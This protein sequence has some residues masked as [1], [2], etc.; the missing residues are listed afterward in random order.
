MNSQ[1]L[2]LG[3]LTGRRRVLRPGTDSAGS[4][5]SSYPFSAMGD[6]AVI[7]DAV[8]GVEI[9][10]V[11]DREY[12]LAIPYSREVD[13]QILSFDIEPNAGEPFGLRDR[14]TG[15]VWTIDGRGVDG[16][17]ADKK[18]RQVPAHNSM[19]FAWVT[20]WQNTDVWQ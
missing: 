10:V 9:L 3:G 15:T 2:P 5:G 7:N 11:R 16:P 12:D 14:E 8:G 13:G 4:M 6:Q 1:E 17:L 19:W 20:F 18:L